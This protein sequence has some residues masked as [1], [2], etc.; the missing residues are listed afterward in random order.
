MGTYAF[1]I[2]SVRVLVLS[3]LAKPHIASIPKS[4]C[5]RYLT[6]RPIETTL[7]GIPLFADGDCTSCCGPDYSQVASNLGNLVFVF[8]KV[9]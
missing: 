3:N 1:G 7:S 4:H 6:R 2:F 9:L 5:S 8:K